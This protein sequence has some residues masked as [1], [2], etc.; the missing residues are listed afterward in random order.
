MLCT[1]S[2]Y[3]ILELRLSKSVICSYVILQAPCPNS[4]RSHFS[5][6]TLSSHKGMQETFFCIE[7]L[8]SSKFAIRFVVV[9]DPH[10]SRLHKYTN[11]AGII[12]CTEN[13]RTGTVNHKMF[14]S[15]ATKS[16]TCQEALAFC[17]S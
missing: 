13:R 4:A 1:T 17:S 2:L 3:N 8:S 7:V 14:K 16:L 15:A 12:P 9:V 6:V 10:V 5:V 11:T